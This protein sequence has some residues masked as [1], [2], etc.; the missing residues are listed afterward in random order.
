MTRRKEALKAIG[1]PLLTLGA[2]LL[3]LALTT[4]Y[5]LTPLWPAKSAVSILIAGLKALLVIA[6]F[7]RLSGASALIRLAAFAGFSWL[8]IL[9][10]LSWADYASR[11]S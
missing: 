1:R 9:F 7:M 11:L 10:A 4:F 5:A 8:M 3:L 2:L 6:V